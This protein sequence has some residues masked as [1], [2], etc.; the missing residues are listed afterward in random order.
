MA[1]IEFK[2]PNTED[3]LQRMLAQLLA[4]AARRREDAH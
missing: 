4:Q 1:S 3:V 2:N